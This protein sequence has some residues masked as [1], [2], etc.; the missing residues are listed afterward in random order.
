MIIEVNPALLDAIKTL[1][2]R[3][4]KDS[5]YDLQFFWAYGADGNGATGESAYHHPHGEYDIYIN[6]N[7]SI[8]AQRRELDKWSNDGWGTDRLDSDYEPEDEE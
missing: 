2:E 3:E 6:G 4:R 1:E 5:G 7:E 8:T